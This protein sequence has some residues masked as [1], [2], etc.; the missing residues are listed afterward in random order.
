[1]KK[2]FGFILFIFLC[3]WALRGCSGRSRVIDS[4]QDPIE[5]VS[6]DDNQEGIGCE[7]GCGGE[8]E[9]F[10]GEVYDDI[11]YAMFMKGNKVLA[12]LAVQHETTCSEATLTFN[13]NDFNSNELNI[14][15]NEYGFTSTSP[16]CY[17]SVTLYD[18]NLPSFISVKMKYLRI[19]VGENKIKISEL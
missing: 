10:N 7:D 12:V 2:I 5:N 16:N 14:L 13:E 3:Y 17:R 9:S 11:T 8:N 19:G 1:M 6:V 15:L 18:W 4:V